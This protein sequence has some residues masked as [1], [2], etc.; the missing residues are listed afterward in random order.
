MEGKNALVIN[1]PEC[2]K[3]EWDWIRFNACTGKDRGLFTGVVRYLEEELKRK[4]KGKNLEDN[5][6]ERIKRLILIG[7]SIQFG[8]IGEDRTVTIEND[9]VKAAIGIMCNFINY[10]SNYEEIKKRADSIKRRPRI[11]EIEREANRWRSMIAFFK[12]SEL[13]GGE[14]SKLFGIENFKE[15]LKNSIFPAIEEK[16]YIRQEIGEDMLA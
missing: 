16:F 8:T 12:Q 3:G 1:I 13:S 11:T 2:L 10:S 5:K 7:E 4:E 9:K 14:Y 6:A 15:T